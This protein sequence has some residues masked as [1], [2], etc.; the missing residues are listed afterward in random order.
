[1]FQTKVVWFGE[2]YKKILIWSG[3]TLLRSDQGHNDF[4][5]WNTIYLIPESNS[6]DYCVFKIDV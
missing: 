1:M 5:K 2:G 4:F 6:L 3:V